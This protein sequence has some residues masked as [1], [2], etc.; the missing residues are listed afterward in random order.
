[1]RVVLDTLRGFAK[2]QLLVVN[3]AHDIIS[4]AERLPT[5]IDKWPR[6]RKCSSCPSSFSRPWYLIYGRIQR[7][8]W[9][10]HQ[11]WYIARTGQN[12]RTRINSICAKWKCKSIPMSRIYN[13]SALVFLQSHS[14]LGIMHAIYSSE[15]S[16]FL[17]FFPA[18]SERKR[19]CRAPFNL[20]IFSETAS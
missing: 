8:D 2:F 13:S 12:I 1:M 5:H 20:F 7:P 3:I 14:N 17:R 11:L 19:F 4:R 6:L 9:L 16:I 10:R 15:L 18:L